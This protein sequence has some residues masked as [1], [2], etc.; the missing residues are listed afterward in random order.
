MADPAG[1]PGARF[2]AASAA[3]INAWAEGLIDGVR[4]SNVS[5][6]QLL[7]AVEQTEI[8]CVQNLFNLVDQGPLTSW[9]DAAGAASPSSRSVRL[10]CPVPPAASCSP[11]RC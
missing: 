6:Q 1:E 5:R 9:P 10:A 8:V 11:V 4:L 7:H 3:L 2:G